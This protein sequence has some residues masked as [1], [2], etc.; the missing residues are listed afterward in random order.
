M[1]KAKHVMIEKDEI[2]KTGVCQ[3]CGPV[4]IVFRKNLNGWRCS[5]AVKEQ[6]GHYIPGYGYIK[7]DERKSLIEAQNNLCTICNEEMNPPCYDHCHISGEFRG[8]LC[9]NCNTGLGLFKD[10]IQRMQNAIRYLQVGGFV[11]EQT[12][13]YN[14]STIGG[15]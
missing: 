10:D 5:V 12:V 9:S 1:P 4:K 11:V 8:M 2:S 3:H 6:K 7:T 15:M 14:E 13:C